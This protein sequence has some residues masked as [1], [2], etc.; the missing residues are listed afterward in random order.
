MHEFDFELQDKKFDNEMINTIIS[1]H[2]G[3]M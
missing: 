3:F 1:L 2:F